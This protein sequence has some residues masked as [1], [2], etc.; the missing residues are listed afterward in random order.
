MKKALLGLTL[1]MLIIG[2]D[3]DRKLTFE[4]LHIE[5]KKC[6]GCPKIKIDIPQAP[7]E[8]PIGRRINSALRE[9]V[10]Y[11]L[12]FEESKNVNTIEHAMASF[13][14]S[15]QALQNKFEDE[16]AGWEADFKGEIVYEDEHLITI[17]LNSYNF[18]GGAHGYGSTFFF[19][20]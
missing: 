2:C 1:L 11:N 15:Y 12:R 13:T 10:I 17:K 5:N 19:K 7:D 6:T 3:K 18:T 4:R 14:R 9:E 8:T 16:T 20:L